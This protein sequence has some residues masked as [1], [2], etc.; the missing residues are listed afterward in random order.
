MIRVLAAAGVAALAMLAVPGAGPALAANSVTISSPTDTLYDAYP[1]MAG[2]VTQSGN[3]ASVTKVDLSLTSVDGWTAENAQLTYNDGASNSSVFTKKS[4]NE[5]DFSWV[6]KP[7]YNGRYTITVNGSGTY[8]SFGT[9]SESSGGSVSFNLELPPAKPTGV[10]AG[11]P[12]GTTDVT[13]TW[14]ANAEPDMV[15][16]QVYRSYQGGNAGPIGKPVAT[17]SKPTFHDDLAGKPQGQYRYAVIAVRRAR[18]CKTESSD[19]AC[20]RTVPSSMSAYSAGVTV[21]AT[22]ATT[23]TTSTTIKKGG[24]STGGGTT[25]TTRSGGVTATT[26][27]SGS[28]HTSTR[29]GGGS[30][31]GGGVDLSQ[32][33]A[34]LGGSKTSKSGGAVDEGTYD[35]E[36]KGYDSTEKPVNADD[37]NNSLIT[38]GGTSVPAPTDDWLRFVGAGSLATAV[39]VHV[40][41]LKQQIDRVPLESIHD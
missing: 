28:G 23:T 13:V 4:G 17:S 16:Y 11:M 41:W 15:G 22:P 32:F 10:A 26:T 20:S 24:G 34:L 35:P 3:N 33:S 38:I 9:H 1:A 5:V 7:R 19:V 2:S 30:A 29:N 14:N 12:E 8:T 25:T 31:P 21:R 18:T 37:D 40:L 27:K 36:L 6:P 39:L